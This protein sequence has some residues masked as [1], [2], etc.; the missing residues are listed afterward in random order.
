MHTLNTYFLIFHVIMSELISLILY[1]TILVTCIV[2]RQFATNILE[3]YAYTSN[4]VYGMNLNEC[5]WLQ[6]GTCNDLCLSTVSV[7]Y[8]HTLFST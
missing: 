1:F 6:E 4:D 8:V 5:R 7:L 2:L 3:K